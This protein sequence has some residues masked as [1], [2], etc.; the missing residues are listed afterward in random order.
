[1]AAQILT[2]SCP[3]RPGIVYTVTRFLF[4]HGANITEAAQHHDPETSLFFMR[5]C[6]DG[7]DLESTQVEEAL[8]TL[9]RSGMA[10]ETTTPDLPVQ[11]HIYPAKA[12]IKTAIWV[13]QEGHCL[14]YLL[15]RTQDGHLPLDITG[16]FSNHL[17]LGPWV[18]A[19]GLPFYFIPVSANS[20]AEAEA[21]AEKEMTQ[22]NVELVILARYM[23]VLS[24]DWCTRWAGQAINIHHSFLPS[25]K[26]AKPYAQAYE[27]GVKLIGATAH[28]VTPVL[29]EGPIIEQDISRV[30]H[31]HTVPD[32]QAQG[33]DTEAL[34]LS[35]AV[36]WHS[37]RRVLLN[38]SKT[39]VFS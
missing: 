37:E 18:Q 7:P 8:Q 6:W 12:K 39:V 25:F 35:R 33:R 36:R 29:D 15:G 1:M 26:G 27:R 30:H 20:K 14:A 22:Q 32:L 21:Q 11:V 24:A 16:V 10:A 23:Q 9:L 28:Y 34:V 19:Q 4:E 17:T 13:S 3:D 2:L 31:G 38:G 5:I